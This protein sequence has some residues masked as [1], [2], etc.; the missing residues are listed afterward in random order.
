MIYT[1]YEM[2]RD[3][4]ADKP[5]GWLHFISNYIPAVRK[6]VAHYAPA[7]ADNLPAIVKSLRQADSPL[8]QT[9]EPAPERWFVA[10]LRQQVIAQLPAAA[11]EPLL[12]I[13]ILSEAWQPLTLTEKLAAWLETMLYATAETGPMLRMASPT[14]EKIR[15][16]A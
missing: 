12:D 11:P 6:I 3:C 8:F 14:V 15:V 1:C 9:L 16:D 7:S 5:E 2:I 13:E 4:R 10:E